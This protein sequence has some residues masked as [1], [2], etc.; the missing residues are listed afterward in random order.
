ML[1]PGYLGLA[2]NHAFAFG[3]PVVSQASP[4]AMRFHSPEVAYIKQ[5]EN[6]LLSEHGSRAAM[7]RALD[8]VLDDQKRYSR[9]ALRFARRHLTVGRMVEGIHAAIAFAAAESVGRDRKT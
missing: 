7:I 6:G 1:I 4:G 9:N 5:G 8:E 2:V 3:V